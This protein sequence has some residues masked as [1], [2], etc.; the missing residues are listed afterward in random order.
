[1]PD[2]ENFIDIGIIKTLRVLRFQYDAFQLFL[3]LGAL[4][5][6]HIKHSV[7]VKFFCHILPFQRTPVSRAP[8]L[9]MP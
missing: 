4:K 6:E 3:K 2:A 5:E 9:A 8:L 7:C 1:M